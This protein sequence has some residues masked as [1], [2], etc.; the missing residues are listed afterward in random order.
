VKK[1]TSFYWTEKH[2]QA[3]QRLKTQLTNAFILPLPKFSKHFELECD[4]SGVG[5][6]TM[7]LQRGHPIAY[8][9]EKLHGAALNY[10]TYD[11]E[12]YALV[13]PCRLG[14]TI[15]FQKNLLFILITSL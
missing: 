12:L 6:G 8:F 15:W 11:K 1:D 2:E 9:S 5:I 4:A 10:P 14:N 13:R 7:L 3:F